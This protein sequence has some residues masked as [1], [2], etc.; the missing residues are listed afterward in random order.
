MP[1]HNRKQPEPDPNHRVEAFVKDAELGPFA[2]VLN[3]H[4]HEILQRW[5]EAA[6]LQRYHADRPSRA[7]AGHIPRLFDALAAFLERSAPRSTDPAAP[8]DDEAVHD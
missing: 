1:R 6:R 3:A 7:V 4:R 8:L 5:L 2:T